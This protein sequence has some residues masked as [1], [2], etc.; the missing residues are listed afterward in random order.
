MGLMRFVVSSPDRIT[1]HAVEQAF[2]S[3]LDRIPWRGQIRQEGDE[4]LLERTTSDSGNLHIPWQVEGHGW[5]TLAT[6]S[7]MERPEPYYLPLELARG[8][9][10]QVRNQLAEWCGI[11]LSVPEAATERLAEAVA[12]FSRAAINAPTSEESVSAA[13]LALRAACDAAALLAA[14]Y[15]DQALAVRHRLGQR[16]PCFLGADLGVSLLEDYAAEQ[17]LKSFDAANVPLVWREVETSEGSRSWRI[18]DRQIQWCKTHHL[19]ISAG[20]LLQ[21]DTHALPDWLYLYEGEFESLQ[22]FA[23]KFVREAV[24]RYRGQ[25]DLWQCVGRSNTAEVLSLSEEERVR[26]TAHCVELARSLDAT[27]PIVVSFDQPWSEYVSRQET[28]FPPLHFA[29]ALARAGLGLTG[30]MLEINLGYCPGGT[31]PR[32]LLEFSRQL[33]HWSVLGLPLYVALTL[34]SST[35]AD[36]LAQRACGFLPANY[37]P[38]TQRT[39]AHRIVSMLLAKA[40]VQG[41]LWNQLCDHEPHSFAHGGLFDLRRHPTPALRMLASLRNAHVAKNG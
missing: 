39:W 16:R 6:G 41:I 5:L 8:K 22:A 25:V 26:L 30:V 18:P 13:G 11:G 19:S 17:F 35:S 37:T 29:D 32:D 1:E 27:T 15:V 14:G 21:F 34:P 12:D 28:D 20:P 38:K 31:L 7:L 23:S 10:A 33:D 9:I 24:T 36:P 40:S 4:I 3:G 2:M